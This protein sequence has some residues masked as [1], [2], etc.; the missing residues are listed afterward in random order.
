M[1]KESASPLTYETS[2]GDN[3]FSILQKRAQQ[4]P[5]GELIK[6]K[7]EVGKWQSFSAAEFL[8]LV[9]LIARGLI[10]RGFKKGDAL[11]ILSST[12]WEWTAFDY[13]ALSIGMVVVPIYQTDSPLQIKSILNDTG[14]KILI[15]EDRVQ[16]EKIAEIQ[17]ELPFMKSEWMLDEGALVTFCELGKAV[18]EEEWEKRAEEVKETDL[19]TIVYTSGSTGEPKGAELTHGMLYCNAYSICMTVPQICYQDQGCYLCFLPLAHIFARSMQFAVTACS[20]SL[21]LEGDTKT[22]L[23][24]FRKVNPT[25]ILGVPRVFEKIYNAA[26]Q[27]AG[28]GASSSVF[29][30][31]V[32]AAKDWSKYQQ[33]KSPI[34]TMVEYRKRFYSRIVYKKILKA[35]GNRASF[36]VTGG[37]PIDRGLSSFFNGMG[38]PLLEGYGLTECCPCVLNPVEGYK[39]GSAGKPIASCSIAV[40]EEGEVLIKGPM[41]FRGYHN[42]PALTAKVMDEEGWFHTGDLGEIDE[43]GFLFITGR[44]KDLIITAGGKNVCPSVLEAAMK[45]CPLVE[46][47]AVIGDKKPF[48]SAL[49]TLNLGAVNEFLASRNLPSQESLKEASQNPLVYNC[50]LRAVDK[51]NEKVSRA[52]SIRKFLILPSEFSAE[53]GLLTPSMKIRREAI[54]KRFKGEIEKKIYSR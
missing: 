20:L 26:T 44:K 4:S 52:E 35:L 22:L 40:S 45:L 23:D 46:E 9:K 34:P 24:D 14:A 33:E 37:A 28:K 21:A 36:A 17:S 2:S 41:V 11:A 16:R 6:Y 51:A 32:R 49:I 5:D 39:V 7:D 47:C 30:K 10:S 3:L 43:D 42:D 13:A 8:D 38:L 15:A 27:K 48:V 50:I 18:A 19:A 54:T 31:A 1:K 12:R 25:L 29:K 53:N